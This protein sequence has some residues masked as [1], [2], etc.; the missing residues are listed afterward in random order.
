MKIEPNFFCSFWLVV[1]QAFQQATG[2]QKYALISE[3]Y[4]PEHKVFKDVDTNGKFKKYIFP[5]G[6][7]LRVFRH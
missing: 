6:L 4:S 7:G 2:A 3:F 1:E 5:L